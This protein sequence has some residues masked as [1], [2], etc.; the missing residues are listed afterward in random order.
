M[1]RYDL[2]AAFDWSPQTLTAPA[3][4]DLS[5]V[6]HAYNGLDARLAEATAKGTE[7]MADNAVRVVGVVW[8]VAASV[9]ATSEESAAGAE[10]MT[11]LTEDIGSSAKTLNLMAQELVR[12][13]RAF[14][15]EDSARPTVEQGQQAA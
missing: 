12:M 6:A 13:A 15:V 5:M 4:H 10:E 8:S 1:A 2:T 9:A 3:N 14:P 11:A 7:S